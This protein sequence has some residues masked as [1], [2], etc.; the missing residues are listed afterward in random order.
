MGNKKIIQLDT[1]SQVNS[2]AYVPI[3]QQ[4]SGTQKTLKAAINSIGNYIAGSQNH[5]SLNT[6]SKNLIGAINEIVQGGGGGSWTD[7]TGT[8]TAGQTSITIQNN[9]IT[10]SST[11]DIYTDADIDYNSVSVSTGSITITFDAQ[12]TN[13]GVKVRVS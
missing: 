2:D 10:T 11:I 5:N 13:L 1:A 4:V 6:T 9:V 3:T 12:S 8:L 7:L